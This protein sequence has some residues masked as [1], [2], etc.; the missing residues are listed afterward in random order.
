MRRRVPHGS[1]F[2]T[3]NV[4]LSVGCPTECLAI[5]INTE[6]CPKSPS[7]ACRLVFEAQHP[8]I[9]ERLAPEP[10][11]GLFC[12]R[13]SKALGI[14]GG[15]GQCIRINE[16]F[17][18]GSAAAPRGGPQMHRNGQKS[19][20]AFT[21]SRAVEGTGRLGADRADARR[22]FS[23]GGI[24]RGPRITYDNG[25]IANEYVDADQASRDAFGGGA[26]R[27]GEPALG[28]ARRRRRR[29]PSAAH[30]RAGSAATCRRLLRLA[31]GLLELGRRALCLVPG[32]Y[33][34]ASLAGAVW[35]P[36]HWIARRREWSWVGGYWRR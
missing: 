10:T 21:V 33:L 24:G 19:N 18:R 14:S 9:R 7:L 5:R 23:E 20:P 28:R 3:W 26:S 11:G 35:V 34:R 8:D 1:R 36:G 15:M 27:G 13:R 4:E 22:R 30:C 31:A 2:G 17:L 16:C 6:A 29:C 32:V 25:F 12:I